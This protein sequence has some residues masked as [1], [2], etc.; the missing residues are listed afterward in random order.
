MHIPQKSSEK[1]H[2]SVVPP[3]DPEEL[4]RRYLSIRAERSR[5][6]KEPDYTVAES[7]NVETGNIL[8]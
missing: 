5:S 3:L 6:K 2:R 8:L 1:G 7:K 4:Y